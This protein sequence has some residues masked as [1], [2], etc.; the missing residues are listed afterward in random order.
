[1]GNTTPQYTFPNK[2]VTAN[3]DEE[4]NLLEVYVA[5]NLAVQLQVHPEDN[6]YTTQIWDQDG[7]TNG[8]V[9]SF[10]ADILKRYRVDG[11]LPVSV[12]VNALDEEHAKE[13]LYDNLVQE[14]DDKDVS[15]LFIV[16]GMKDPHV[17]L[18]V[19]GENMGE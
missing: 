5:G 18:D 6:I 19:E 11:Y 16:D 4:T 13:L 1:M 8:L 14:L 12:H 9:M 2:F 10:E 17:I 7:T 3:Y 15:S